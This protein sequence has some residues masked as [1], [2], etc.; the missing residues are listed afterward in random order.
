M[1]WEECS[2]QRGSQG[3][4]PETVVRLACGRSS[5]GSVW[6]ARGGLVSQCGIFGLLLQ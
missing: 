4:G 6:L 1:P 2:K 5:R 3:R